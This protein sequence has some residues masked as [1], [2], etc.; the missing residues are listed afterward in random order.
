LGEK[1]KPLDSGFEAVSKA[2]QEAWQASGIQ[3]L[4]PKEMLDW[5]N[6]FEKIRFKA[7]EIERVEREI[8]LKSVEREKLRSGMLEE[9]KDLGE[10]RE[11]K[12]NPLDPILI[13]CEMILDDFRKAKRK[14]EKLIEKREELLGGIE[15]ARNDQ[16]GAEERL[17]EWHER[18]KGS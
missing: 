3:P 16:Q 2:W 4:P 6:G 11:F 9:I 12:R 17:E 15:E 1:E 8:S 13:S 5:L 10:V 14:R 18:W 7:E